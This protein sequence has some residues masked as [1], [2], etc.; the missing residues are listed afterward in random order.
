M[1]PDRMVTRG[2]DNRGREGEQGMGAGSEERERERRRPGV[3]RDERV[4]GIHGWGRVGGG[5]GGVGGG[6]GGSGVG[7]AEAS[8]NRWG[9]RP[10]D[11]PEPVL[12][13]LQPAF[14]HRVNSRWPL[15]SGP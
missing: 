13:E 15:S 4:E 3:L 1:F 6:G 12:V 10:P 7:I 2:P 9:L 14:M 5:V 11:I 8:R